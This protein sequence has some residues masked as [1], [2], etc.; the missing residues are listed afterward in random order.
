[1][2]RGSDERNTF[3]LVKMGLIAFDRLEIAYTALKETYLASSQPVLILTNMDVDAV[4]AL[5]MLIVT[6]H[7]NLVLTELLIC[8]H[9]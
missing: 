3:S 4:C 5:K 2:S 1:M 7:L 9:D 8:I 6:E